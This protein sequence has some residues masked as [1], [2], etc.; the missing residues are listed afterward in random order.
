M[1]WAAS[2]SLQSIDIR[3]GHASLGC[4]TSSWDSTSLVGSA[5]SSDTGTSPLCSSASWS[6]RPDSSALNW[7]G[8]LPN[9]VLRTLE[10]QQAETETESKAG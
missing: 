6:K 9:R 1:S 3:C 2:I 10:V 4:V 8:V 7:G 5:P